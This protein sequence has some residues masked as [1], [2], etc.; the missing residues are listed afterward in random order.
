MHRLA[1]HYVPSNRLPQLLTHL[2]ALDNPSHDLINATIEELYEERMSDEPPPTLIGVER[3]ALDVAFG[4]DEVEDIMEH[5]KLLTS[6][7]DKPVSKWAQRTTDELHKRSPTSLKVALR[8]IREGAT[9]PLLDCL[10]M[11]LRIATAYCVGACLYCPRD[12]HL[13]SLFPAWRKFRF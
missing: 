3:E 11:E 6:S 1:T 7:T 10:R 8:A 13:H 2:A 4:H 5:L 12:L 9:K